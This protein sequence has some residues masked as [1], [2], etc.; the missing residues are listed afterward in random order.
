MQAYDVT[1]WEY[2][3]NYASVREK[4]WCAYCNMYFV[5]PIKICRGFSDK[6]TE[7]ISSM[8]M[9][10]LNYKNVILYYKN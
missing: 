1:N 8:H 10:L 2:L 9:S 7:T 3:T 5:T 6:L 4:L